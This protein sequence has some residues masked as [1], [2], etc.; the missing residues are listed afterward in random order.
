MAYMQT[1]RTVDGVEALY[2]Y[3]WTMGWSS[4]LYLMVLSPLNAMTPR[5]MIIVWPFLAMLIPLLLRSQPA[6]RP[7]LWRFILGLVLISGAA[8]VYARSVDSNV[9]ERLLE[10]VP[11]RVVVDNVHEGILPRMVLNFPDETLVFAA[12]QSFL[13]ENPVR[14]VP[15]LQMDATDGAVY[16]VNNLSYGNSTN[17]RDALLQQISMF[18][19]E[20]VETAFG[21]IYRLGAE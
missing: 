13:L 7:F 18:V 2:L 6:W 14:W 19:Y 20:P 11:D 17:N 8:S 12:D 21:T 16:Y 4:F 15:E 9:S 10:T 1:V 5:H 3:L